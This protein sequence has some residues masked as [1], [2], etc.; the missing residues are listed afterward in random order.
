[1]VA[2]RTTTE[3]AGGRAKASKPQAEL[4]GIQVDDDAAKVAR[5]KDQSPCYCCACLSGSKASA[6][7]GQGACE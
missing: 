3:G 2:R 6:L 7:V 4:I 5:R 1:M